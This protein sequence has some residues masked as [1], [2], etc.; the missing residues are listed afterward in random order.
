M[1]VQGV[2]LRGVLVTDV[3]PAVTSGLELYYD[4]SQSASYP[5]SG[6]TLYD[7]SASGQNATISGSLTDAG[8]WFTFTGSQ[9]I[10][11]G[12]LLTLFSGWQHSIEVWVNPSAVGSVFSDTGTGPANVGYHTTGLEFYSAG[13][14]VLSSPML[15]SSTSTTRVGVQVTPL[16]NW[17]QIIRV[18][19]G[20]NTA[21]SYVNGTKSSETSIVWI[22]PDPGWHLNF[23]SSDSTNFSTGAAF[24][25]KLGVI[26]L[27]NRVLTQAEVTQNYNATK[28]L[29]GL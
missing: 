11:T 9:S 3:A 27:Y 14:S 2:T 5:G 20:S 26:R 4:P 21:Y 18:Y 13:P 23:G 25:G 28:A 24:Q 16:N 7:L 10:V 6:T 1:I 8:N 12:N 15:W 29:Y 17:Y 19:N 22:P